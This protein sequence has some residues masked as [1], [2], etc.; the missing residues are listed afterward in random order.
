[1]KAWNMKL[2]RVA[3]NKPVAFS[4]PIHTGV[5]IPI[6]WIK[7]LESALYA[8]HFS[9]RQTEDVSQLTRQRLF[10]SKATATSKILQNI[11][12][13]DRLLLSFSNCNLNPSTCLNPIL[14]TMKTYSNMSLQNSLDWDGFAQHQPCVHVQDQ[15]LSMVGLLVSYSSQGLYWFAMAKCS[16]FPV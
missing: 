16:C 13:A 1:M 3:T 10:T 14:D 15:C 5:Q 4:F 9:A 2:V 12:I 11:S 7:E 8:M 6:L